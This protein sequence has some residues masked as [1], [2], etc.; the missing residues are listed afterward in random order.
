MGRLETGI[1]VVASASVVASL[2][3]ARPDAQSEGAR[4]SGALEALLARAGEYV[5]RFESAFSNVVSEERYV[6]SIAPTGPTFVGDPRTRHRELVSDFLLVRVP[7]SEGWLPFRDVFEVDG[8]PVRDHQDRLV[9]LFVTPQNTSPLERAAEITEQSARYN[10]GTVRTV[11]QP[12]LALHVVRTS[13][14]PRFRF[15]T[16]KADP[17][18]GPAVSAVE[19]REEMTPS[20]IRGPAGRDM[21]MR[22]RLWI[23]RPTGRVL[24]S[25][26]IV[27]SADAIIITRF[28]YDAAFETT[29]PVEMQEEY[30]QANGTRMV[31]IAK[32]GRFRR[33]RVDVQYGR[34]QGKR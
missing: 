8:V 18:V 19:Y 9:K 29:I 13:Q 28:E 3:V 16:P 30:L 23:D 34:G 14:Q 11:N 5:D 24:R 20:V 7:G 27:D 33:F 10:I 32:Y 31:G 21:L 1:R 25:E 17:S 26:V 2:V 6:Q 22:G 12:L 4:E 15:S